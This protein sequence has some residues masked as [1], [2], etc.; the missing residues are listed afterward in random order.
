MFRKGA[1]RKGLNEFM[2]RFTHDNLH[3]GTFF[4]KKA[5]QEQ[6]L[7]GTNGTCN[8]EYYFLSFQ[9]EVNLIKKPRKFGVLYNSI[10]Y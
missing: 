2:C 5:Q 4:H 10:Q 9:H 6:R 1:E 8:G 7:V 3:L